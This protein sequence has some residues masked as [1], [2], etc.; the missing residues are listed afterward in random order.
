M[1]NRD[2]TIDCQITN[3]SHIF[4]GPQD[5]HPKSLRRFVR[6]TLGPRRVRAIKN[7][8]NDCW[9]YYDRLKG[10]ESADLT[11]YSQGAELQS[12]DLVRVR[13]LDEI[14]A[15]LNHWGQLRGCSFA[16]EMEQY[17]GT[18]QQILKKVERFVDERDFKILRTR[19]IYLLNE[20][21]CQG[22]ASLGRCDR[23]CYFF[24]REEWLEKVEEPIIDF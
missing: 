7:F 20:I 10:R 9:N 17:C 8:V 12:G 6:K 21:N 24:W 3:L 23:N 2:T 18:T 11:T 5:K 16:P 19:G 14:K 22:V 15:T 4:E 1:K 13:T